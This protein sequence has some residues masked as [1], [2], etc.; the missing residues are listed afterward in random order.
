MI[1]MEFEVLSVKRTTVIAISEPF[2]KAGRVKFVIAS[3]YC[4]CSA[5]VGFILSLIYNFQAAT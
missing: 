5:F 1:L 3:G 2:F 4:Y